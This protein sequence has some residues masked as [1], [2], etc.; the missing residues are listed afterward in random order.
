MT[1][2]FNI[3][4]MVCLVEDFAGF[5]AG[6]VGTVIETDCYPNPK[7]VL[8]HLDMMKGGRIGG[9]FGRRLRPA[10]TEDVIGSKSKFKIGDKVRANK[11]SDEHYTITNFRSGWTGTV[12]DVG[13]FDWTD[14]NRDDIKV[15]GTDGE[16]YSVYSKYFDLIESP[17]SSELHITVNGNETIAVYKHDGKTEKAVAK[18]SPE[19]KFDFKVGAKIALE[20]LGVLPAEIVKTTKVKLVH[21]SDNS[22]Y[23]VCGT[24]TKYKDAHGNPLAVGDQVELYSENIYY[25]TTVI[26]KNESRKFVMGIQVNCDEDTGKTGSWTMIK[27]KDWR[28]IK[29]GSTNH[30]IKYKIIL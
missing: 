4:D 9:V 23:G 8:Y 30:N 26:V 17:T 29:I 25:G 10:S 12:V 2:Q 7:S 14:E 16:I 28:D 27:V 13:K 24:P 11:Y 15:K 5:K 22:D 19:D 3:G 21:T 6:S 20:R 1:K 18:C